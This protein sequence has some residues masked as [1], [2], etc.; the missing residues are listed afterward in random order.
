MSMW[1]RVKKITTFSNYVLYR[2][3]NLNC[4]QKLSFLC[5]T[6]KIVN[7]SQLLVTIIETEFYI[8]FSKHKHEV[9]L[10]PEKIKGMACSIG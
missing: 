8:I 10:T 4:N 2:N 7:N 9:V 3:W 5:F 1:L 6:V